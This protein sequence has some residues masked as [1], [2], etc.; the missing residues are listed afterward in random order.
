LESAENYTL[1][2]M[3]QKYRYSG[4]TPAFGKTRVTYIEGRC[5][6]GAS[7]IN[8]GLYHR[9]MRETLLEWQLK[10]Q[11]DRLSK[12]EL[13]PYFDLVEAEIGVSKQ[14]AGEGPAS[15]CLRAGARS[16]GWRS[17]EIARFWKYQ[18]Q[19]DGRFTGRRRSMTETLIPRALRAGARLMP[20]T[21]IRHLET[22]GNGA[23]L[24]VGT[25]KGPDGRRRN[26]RIRFRDVFVCGGAVQ[27]PL[28]LR[29]SGIT[30]RVGD[31]LRMHPMVRIAARFKERIND[32]SWG[33]PVHQVEEFK[34]HMTLGCSHSS[35]PHI[36]LWLC[37][38]LPDKRALLE[39]WEHIAVF[40]VAVTG[41]GMGT[42]RNLPLL[43]QPLVRYPLGEADLALLGEG[44]HKLGQLVFAAGA[45]EVFNPLPGGRTLRSPAEVAEVRTGLPQGRVN[46]TTIH[47]FSSCPMGE[48]D[49]RCAVDSFGKLHGWQNIYL[50]D[51][52]ILPNTPGVNPQG[53]ILAIAR[54]N[55]D[56]YLERA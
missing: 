37:G 19:S 5:V 47:L 51:A 49:R 7:E 20:D 41:A 16:L 48:D 54:R 27:T 40:Y 50:N 17:T 36:A 32:P 33:V 18:Q 30:A 4:L 52:S 11:V 42:I 23:T 2:E 34:P 26:V 43:D 45:T 38:D 56:H 10:Y 1:A 8:A 13:D 28:I 31:S 9:P 25:S 46:V 39:D 12:E 53:T 21:T 3:D 55:V 44:L 22:A 15:D 24:A 6:G 14:P 29:R 35:M